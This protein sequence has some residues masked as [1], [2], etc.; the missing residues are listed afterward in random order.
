MPTFCDCETC[1]TLKKK[2]KHPLCPYCKEWHDYRIA[3]P[4][5]TKHVEGEKGY[6]EGGIVPKSTNPDKMLK[7]IQKT[8]STGDHMI[9]KDELA[10]ASENLERTIKKKQYEKVK[11]DSTL[12]DRCEYYIE[13]EGGKYTVYQEKGGALKALRYGEPWQDLCGNNLV[14]YLMVELIEAKEKINNALKEYD[15]YCAVNGD[16]VAMIVKDIL[17]ED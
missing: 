6:S 9:R 3:C 10:K 4:E 13:L 12:K 15:S 8:H 1:R 5:Y 16:N 7:L 17:E 2:L 11:E 14:F